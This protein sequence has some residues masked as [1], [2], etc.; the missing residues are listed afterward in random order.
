MRLFVTWFVIVLAFACTSCTPGTSMPPDAM[1]PPCPTQVVNA[2][3]T[4][5]GVCVID[6]KECQRVEP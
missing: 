4:H 1:L 5:T 3:C 2:T 6:G